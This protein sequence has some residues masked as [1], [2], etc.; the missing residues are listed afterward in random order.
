MSG[1]ALRDK[2]TQNYLPE[3]KSRYVIMDTGVSYALIPGSDFVTIQDHLT[4]DYGVKCTEPASSS[5]V[6][7]YKCSCKSYKDL[8]DI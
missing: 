2:K 7:T 1:V 5:L 3:I 4:Q 6:S 8:P